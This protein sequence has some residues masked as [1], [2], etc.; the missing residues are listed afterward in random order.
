MGADKNGN[1]AYAGLY[2]AGAI[3]QLDGRT[4]SLVAIRQVPN[5]R[6]A[7]PYKMIADRNHNVWF[8]NSAADMLGKFNPTTEKFVMYP[9]PTRG[10]NS[11]HLGIDETTDPPTVWV[12]YTGAG[13]VARVQFRTNTAKD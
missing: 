5:G 12:P 2:W 8:S 7:Q 9:L 10:T 4:K 11:R 6:W 13:K 1:F 3:A